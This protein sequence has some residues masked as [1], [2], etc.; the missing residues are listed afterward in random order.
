[1]IFFF[2]SCIVFLVRFLCFILICDKVRGLQAGLQ[3]GGWS[4][5]LLTLDPSFNAGYSR[6]G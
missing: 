6:M 5:S 1:M 2:S 4:K 3:S